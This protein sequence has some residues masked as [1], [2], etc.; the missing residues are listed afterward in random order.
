MK[1]VSYKKSAAWSLI[2][3]VPIF[4]AALYFAF[5][6]GFDNNFNGFTSAAAII[7]ALGCLFYGWQ[8][9]RVFFSAAILYDDQQVAFAKK[10]AKR[11]F[12]DLSEISNFKHQRLSETASIMSSS[13]GSALDT[14]HF[15]FTKGGRD[16]DFAFA[17]GMSRRGCLNEAELQEFLQEIR[18]KL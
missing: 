11:E 18:S 14:D 16:Y 10:F 12:F 7:V 9:V 6:T 2:I 5:V 15:T 4:F 3:L 8:A 13:A 1:K 17:S